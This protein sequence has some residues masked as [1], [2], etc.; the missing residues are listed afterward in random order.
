MRTALPNIGSPPPKNPEAR[1]HPCSSCSVLERS[2][3]QAQ[4]LASHAARRRC[5]VTAGTIALPP[6]GAY[7]GRA[8][9]AAPEAPASNRQRPLGFL[10]VA[11]IA[12]AFRS[13]PGLGGGGGGGGGGGSSSD[14]TS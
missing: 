9:P 3:K 13:R 5:G 8:A 2:R 7:P 14:P 11:A 12:F 6:A 10:P 4:R 1:T